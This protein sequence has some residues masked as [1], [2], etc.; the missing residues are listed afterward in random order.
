MNQVIS[1]TTKI[2]QI[3]VEMVKDALIELKYGTKQT[4][5]SETGLSV[6]T[7]GNILNE[8]VE[9]GEV[10]EVDLEQPSGGRPA[11]RFMYNANYCY[12]AC[13]YVSYEEGVN[14]I[15]HAVTNLVGEIIEEDSVIVDSVSYESI[16]SLIDKL[17][18]KYEIIKAIGMG[19]PAVVCDGDVVGNC[20]IKELSNLP[21]QKQLKKLFPIEI[22]V[23]NDMNLKALGFY[24]KQNFHNSKSI[25]VINFP[26]DNCIGSGIIVDGHI[27]KGNTNFAGEVSYLPLGLSQDDLIKELEKDDQFLRLAVKIITS[28]ITV[29]NP[30]TIALTGELVRSDMIEEIISGCLKIVPKEHMPEIIVRENIHDDYINGLVSVTIESLACD[31][32][33]VKKRIF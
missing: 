3:N 7:C 5:S 1:N 22:I 27:I 4:I 31:V 6:A 12:V 30:A 18:A 16:V 8:L 20:D 33:L 11:R 25:A 10:I 9:S 23:E 19:V 17:V 2:K 28:I 14:K 15:T 21:L 29:I 13:I 26:K 32:Q 24:R